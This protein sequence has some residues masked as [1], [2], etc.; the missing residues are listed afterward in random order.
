MTVF[1]GNAKPVNDERPATDLVS[2]AV[3][4]QSSFTSPDGFGPIGVSL[5]T[6]M[7]SRSG[8]R[9][10]LGR[11]KQRRLDQPP[12]RYQPIVRFQATEAPRLLLPPRRTEEEPPPTFNTLDHRQEHAAALRRRLGWIPGVSHGLPG[13]RIQLFKRPVA[14]LAEC[15]SLVRELLK[16]RHPF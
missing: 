10:F 7:P 3:N 1:A 6:I 13:G 4:L 9:R 2:V 14:R 8:A 11:R 12:L 15:G 5:V 16:R